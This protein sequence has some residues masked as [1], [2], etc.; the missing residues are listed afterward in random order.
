MQLK[1][2]ASGLNFGT[3]NSFGGS[4]VPT[5]GMKLTF[6]GGCIDTSLWQRDANSEQTTFFSLIS[7][8]GV[9]LTLK[10]LFAPVFG[11]LITE[12][13]T[14]KDFL[15]TPKGFLTDCVKTARKTGYSVKKEENETAEVFA[16]RQAEKFLCGLFGALY[17]TNVTEDSE[18]DTLS[19][20]IEVKNCQE[21]QDT[22]DYRKYVLETAKA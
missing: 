6:S 22:S 13:G 16:K 1:E 4:I 20:T 10:N 9:R 21:M 7:D 18:L 3:R 19:V 15:A 5:V 17:G 2:F 12:K 8:E 14:E 11:T